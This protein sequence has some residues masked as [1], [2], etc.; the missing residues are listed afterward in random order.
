MVIMGVGMLGVFG[1][2]RMANDATDRVRQESEARLLAER[3]MVSLLTRSANELQ[4]AQGKEGR[5]SWEEKVQSAAVNGL[6][7]LIVVVSW[8]SRGQPA[9]FELISFRE[10]R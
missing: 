7:R 6:G 4:P 3:H 9:E 10:I 2:L 5:F 8:E 1:A